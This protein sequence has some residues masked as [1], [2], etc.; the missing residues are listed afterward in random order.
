MFTITAVNNNST[1]SR[2]F[3]LEVSVRVSGYVLWPEGVFLT[4]FPLP[5]ISSF[6][7]LIVCT[8]G[9]HK[10]VQGWPDPTLSLYTISIWIQYQVP[11]I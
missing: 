3:F 6:T 11:G 7:V 4:D 5:T 1:H 8:P 10:G 2:V 9:T